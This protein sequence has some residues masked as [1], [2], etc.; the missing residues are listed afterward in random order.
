MTAEF[1]ET[2]I[3]DTNSVTLGLFIK[4][5]AREARTGA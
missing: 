2:G 3:Q 1:K 5:G 4:G